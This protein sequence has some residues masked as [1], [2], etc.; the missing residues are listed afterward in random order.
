MCFTVQLSWFILFRCLTTAILD[1]H[2]FRVLSTTFFI[3]FC[4]LLFAVIFLTACLLYHVFRLLSRTK[5]IFLN[6]FWIVCL[7]KTIPCDSFVIIPP[8][9]D[10][11]NTFFHVFWEEQ[12]WESGLRN[13]WC[14]GQK[15]PHGF[16][17]ISC[18]HNPAK[19]YPPKILQL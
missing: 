6:L 1:Y 14:W 18:S 17:R 13:K 3:F 7:F 5:F 4:F 12:S 8:T 9:S 19:Q 11:V 15:I 16:F 10:N 2:I